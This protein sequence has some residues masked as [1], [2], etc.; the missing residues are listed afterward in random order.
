VWAEDAVRV[1]FGGWWYRPAAEKFRNLTLNWTASQVLTPN[2]TTLQKLTPSARILSKMGLASYFIISFAAATVC[3][4]RGT[5]L[6]LTT[7]GG[8]GACEGE[9]KEIEKTNA[10]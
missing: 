4:R 8:L 7:C 6:P 2:S 5:K 9:K 3:S 10:R 1:G